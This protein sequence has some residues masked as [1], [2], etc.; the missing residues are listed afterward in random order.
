MKYE[1]MEPVVRV[2]AVKY[3]EGYF[4]YVDERKN[5]I[6]QQKIMED[7]YGCPCPIVPVISPTRASILHGYAKY[8]DEARYKDF[9]AYTNY[10]KLLKTE[11]ALKIEPLMPSNDEMLS[12]TTEPKPHY[13]IRDPRIRSGVWKTMELIY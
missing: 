12:Y 5:A 7:N 6:K 8:D 10:I 2:Y 1:E 9:K 11:E 4:S 13:E 3:P